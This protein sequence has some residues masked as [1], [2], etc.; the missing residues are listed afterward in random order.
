MTTA[1]AVHC[2]AGGGGAASGAARG[3]VGYPKQGRADPAAAGAGR[4]GPRPPQADQVSLQTAVVHADGCAAGHR[5]GGAA[6][7]VIGDATVAASRQFLPAR[8]VVSR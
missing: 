7:A 6:I 4:A 3:Q 1:F 8:S 5:A 2:P